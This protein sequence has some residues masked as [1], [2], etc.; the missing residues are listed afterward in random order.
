MVVAR[1]ELRAQLLRNF[2]LRIGT[3]SVCPSTVSRSD[4]CSGI[5]RI[6]KKSGES[7][8]KAPFLR[9]ASPDR[10]R[11]S[12]GKE[13]MQLSFVERSSYLLNLSLLLFRNCSRLPQF[14][15]CVERVVSR[16]K[17]QNNRVI[18]SA[19]VV[20]HAPSEPALRLILQPQTFTHCGLFLLNN[21]FSQLWRKINNQILGSSFRKFSTFQIE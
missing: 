9:T 11:K 20:N 16:T 6:L 7:A 8:L 2:L 19:N 1:A 18:K 13:T 4:L 10:K 5:S 12:C 14:F 21:F 3:L 15:G 17:K